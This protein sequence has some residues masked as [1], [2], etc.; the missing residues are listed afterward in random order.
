M[1]AIILTIL[2]LSFSFA[3]MAQL[4]CYDIQYTTNPNGSSYYLGQTVTVQGIVTAIK[5]GS[6]LYIGDAGGGPWSG[7]YVYHGVTS[8]LVELGD[9]VELTGVVD[10]YYN[11]TELTNISS[12]AFI[13][14]NN[15]VPVTP[16]STADLPYNS[17]I[18][19]PYEGVLVR[20]NEIQV[21]SLMDMYSQFRIA[22][23]SGVQAQVDDVLYGPPAS[24]IVVDEWWYQIQG[25]VDYHNAA[26]YKI[27]PR[28]AQDLVRGDEAVITV[29][30]GTMDYGTISNGNSEVQTFIINNLSPATLNVADISIS[31]AYF[32]LEALPTLPSNQGL[33]S[34]ISF[35]VKYAPLEAG[36]HSGMVTITSNCSPMQIPLS[37][38]CIDP[39][40]Q[41][42]VP[43]GFEHWQAGTVQ[44]VSWQAAAVSYVNVLLSIDNGQNWSQLNASPVLAALGSFSFIVP[45]LNSINCLIK[46]QNTQDSTC[47]DVSDNCFSISDQ[48][49]P[50]ELLTFT[51]IVTP[52]N[53]VQINWVTRSEANLMGFYIYRNSVNEQ[54]SASSV[55]PLIPASNTSDLQSYTFTDISV[56]QGLWYYWL[57]SMELNGSSYFHGSVVVTVNDVSVP[58]GTA[59]PLITG[60]KSIHPN[61]FKPSTTITIELSK[62]SAIEMGIYNLKGELIR[63]LDSGA[64]AAGTHSL[65]WNGL[66]DRGQACG[67]GIYLLKFTAEGKSSQAKLTLLK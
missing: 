53:Y 35:D 67:N 22:D 63:Q 57:Q 51:A 3:L 13:S 66:D 61:P 32:S 20:F 18:S 27:L 30:P 50:V 9:L 52:Q 48:A 23:V 42:M 31:G 39:T 17:A 4:S 26:G 37:G 55:S 12:F 28:S 8:N 7:L 36:A 29:S 49:P 10:E 56:T 1:K 24:Q 43:N 54:A 25:V 41:V 2:V 19:E 44:T 11:L 65:L 6:G 62:A 38:V 45:Q 64:K 60:I 58:G 47:F 34:P 59:A 21:K 16:L 46:V 33:N 40:V 15:P 5:R 14:R